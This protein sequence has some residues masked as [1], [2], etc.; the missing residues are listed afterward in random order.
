VRRSSRRSCS[1][2]SLLACR[3]THLALRRWLFRTWAREHRIPT[4]RVLVGHLPGRPP[5]PHVTRAGYRPGV[6]TKRPVPQ[7]ASATRRAHED[8]EEGWGRIS[9][10]IGTRTVHVSRSPCSI[11]PCVSRSQ[12]KGGPIGFALR[13]KELP[14]QGAPFLR[15]TWWVQKGLA[16][17]GPPVR[18]FYILCTTLHHNIAASTTVANLQGLT[19]YL[20]LAKIYSEEYICVAALVAARTGW[21]SIVREQPSTCVVPCTGLPPAATKNSSGIQAGG[22]F[23]R[24]TIDLIR[25]SVRGYGCVPVRTIE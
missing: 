24:D 13:R 21:C 18:G 16:V 17:V 10:H 15:H 1:D 8:G 11:V 23:K 6:I 5:C 20:P 19:V 7:L 4:R 25:A 9:T 2:F 12:E 3:S 14:A 22:A